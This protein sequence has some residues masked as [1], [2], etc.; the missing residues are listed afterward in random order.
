MSLP[1]TAYIL[2]WY[3]LP[4]ETFIFR[5]VENARA[6]GMLTV[7]NDVYVEYVD[8]FHHFYSVAFSITLDRKPENFD[9][10]TSDEDE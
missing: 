4:S 9:E 3:P 2:L 1:K 5:E 8:F 7:P 10:E 6:A